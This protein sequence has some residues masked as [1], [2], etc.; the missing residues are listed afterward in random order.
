MQEL[1]RA[2]GNSDSPPGGYAHKVSHALRLCTMQYFHRNL[3][4]TYLEVSYGLQ[5]RR[6]LAVTLCKGKNTGN[7]DP[8]KY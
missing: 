7:R 6:G 4:Q 8:R 3:G 2:G 1:H 5:D